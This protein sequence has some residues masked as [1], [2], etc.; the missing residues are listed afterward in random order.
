[1]CNIDES[2][3]I[4]LFTTGQIKQA[5]SAHSHISHRSM[6]QVEKYLRPGR[7]WKPIVS[8]TQGLLR[9]LWIGYGKGKIWH[10][11]Y[12][13]QPERWGGAQVVTVVDMI[14]ERF[15]NLFALS[16]D[17]QFREQKRRCVLAADAVICIS[18]NTKKDVQQFYGIDTSRVRVIPLAC[19]EVFM[20][21]QNPEPN[22]IPIPRKPFLLYVGY[23]TH[24]KNFD[25]LIKAYSQWQ[26]RSE[27][28]L[29]VVGRQWSV[30]ERKKL[31]ASGID[32]Q[33]HLFGN[34]DDQVLT[35]LYRTAVAFVYPSFYEGFGIPLLEAMACG[36]PVVAS[37]I[38]ST[39]EVAGDCP[40]YFDPA[41]VDDL[42]VAL[43]FALI[44]GRNSVRCR[45]GLKRV[46][47]F[48]WEKTASE[49]L[50]VYRAIS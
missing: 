29:V 33:V 41:Q 24:Y 45:N 50:K 5:L 22:P 39:I 7:L 49:T 47:E 9:K 34:V 11:T 20:Q 12:F 36:C 18:E 21:I 3:L 38:P 42:I 30:D 10:S 23:R 1:M 14:Y 43:D 19:S 31:V 15:P 26:N 37:R 17:E 4:T 35:R 2:L 27:V 40:I 13:T 6:P 48:S 32:G 28:D 16:V 25:A 46:K 8:R 44:E